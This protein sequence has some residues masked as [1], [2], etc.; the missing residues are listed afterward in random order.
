MVSRTNVNDRHF[1]ADLAYNDDYR[2][3]VNAAEQA[4]R[5]AAADVCGTGAVI[6]D[7]LT[8]EDSTSTGKFKINPGRARD[9]DKRNIVISSDE[10]NLNPA[11]DST[12]ANYI[13]VR[14]S[15]SDSSAG[16]AVKTGRPYSRVRADAY[17]IDISTTR[18]DETKGWVNLATATGTWP[19]REFEVDYP[20]RSRGPVRDVAFWTFTYPGELEDGGDNELMYHHGLNK[21]VFTIP[22]D[23]VIHR[24]T[25]TA[26]V[27]GGGLIYF[28]VL[29]NGSEAIALEVASENKF[30]LSWFND[31]GF[32][33]LGVNDTLQIALSNNS[34]SSGP[35][36]IS[37]VV[38]GYR[39]GD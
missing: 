7:G 27:S 12:G 26:R 11:E 13:A 25:F 6:F 16:N 39:V 31:S 8:V 10:D 35:T 2:R 15:W 30:P 36:D 28:S 33:A 3:D 20:N 17:E 18:H 9:T 38:A 23:F 14:H 19:F 29:A 32:A 37:V 4:V 1:L 22:F 21:D 24:V 5:E 34:G